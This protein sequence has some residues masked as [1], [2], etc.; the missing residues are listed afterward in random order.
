MKKKDEPIFFDT[1]SKYPK[2]PICNSQLKSSLSSLEAHFLKV[3][4]KK[5]SPG[6]THRFR[7]Y[8]KNPED[9]SYVESYNSHPNEVTGGLPSLGK[10]R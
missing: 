4:G 10:R 5:P 6:E 7:S 9:N 8:M 3:H 1:V 2:C